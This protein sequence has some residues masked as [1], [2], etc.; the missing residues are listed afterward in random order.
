LGAPV[1]KTLWGKMVIPDDSPYTTGGI[2][3]L[4][5]AGSAD[6]VDDIDTLLIL[7]TNFLYTKYLPEPGKITVVQVEVDAD[8]ARAGNRLPTDVPLI[9]DVGATLEALQPRL[10]RNSERKHLAK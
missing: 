3:L 8:A 7:G 5:T 10:R 4:G 2:G 9:G 1:I 6:L